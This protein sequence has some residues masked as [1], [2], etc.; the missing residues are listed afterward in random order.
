[1]GNKITPHQIK[2]AIFFTEGDHVLQNFARIHRNSLEKNL[3]MAALLS[4]SIVIP[5][6]HVVESRLTFNILKSNPQLLVKGIVIPSIPRQFSS[7]SEYIRERF[8]PLTNDREKQRFLFAIYEFLEENAATFLLRDDEGMRQFYKQSLL[9]D[10]ND[11]RSL[12][13]R[14]L[15]L[16]PMDLSELTEQVFAIESISRESA[17]AL[18]ERLEPAR[19]KV[20]ILYLE[21]L[22]CITGSLGNNSDPLLNPTLLPFLQDRVTRMS[23]AHD[24]GLF[25]K[26]LEAIGIAQSVLDRIPLSE[27]P[28]LS[29]ES[30]VRRFRE[31]YYELI[32]KARRGLS[33]VLGE[34]FAPEVLQDVLLDLVEKKIKRE[35]S[36]AR[37]KNVWEFSSFATA[38]ISFGVALSSHNYLD[39]TL[40]GAAGI[41]NL[42]D[43]AF[44]LSDPLVS[45]ILNTK[46]EFIAFSST[47]RKRASL[48]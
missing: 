8:A 17:F 26:V 5:V 6:S 10:L 22:Y 39:S 45:R 25:S 15:Q 11:Q 36:V 42:L 19:K 28:D 48:E 4:E 43:F 3:K 20:F 7:V 21:T 12:L 40:A 18:A 13:L 35:Q 32:D 38:L 23:K 33:N 27:I 30:T 46:T 29:R 9:K 34:E 37:W 44:D 41:I 31:K 47:L 2:N 16:S 1:M 24:P 14:S